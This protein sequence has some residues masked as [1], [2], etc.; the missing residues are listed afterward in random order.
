MYLIQLKGFPALISIEHIQTEKSEM[1][2]YMLS[3]CWPSIMSH[4]HQESVHLFLTFRHWRSLTHSRFN[5]GGRG[6]VVWDGADW[7]TTSTEMTHRKY[8]M[9]QKCIHHS[10]A[11]HYT[12]PLST[13][14]DGWHIRGVSGDFKG[15][16][17]FWLT[18]SE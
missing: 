7:L 10:S 12:P 3:N 9:G 1:N 8:I 5:L 15:S 4:R 16:V 2:V 6:E 17:C 13:C 11:S 18:A 14:W